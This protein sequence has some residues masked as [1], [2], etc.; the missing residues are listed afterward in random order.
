MTIRPG[1]PWGVEVAR[2]DDLVEVPDDAGLAGRPGVPTAVRGGDLFRALGAPQ[3]RDP[4]QRVEIDG[5]RVVIDDV[6]VDGVAHVVMRRGRRRGW[7]RGPIVAVMNVEHL[8]VWNVAPRA[9][10]NDGRLD[11]VEV[12]SEMS[13]RDRWT[14]RRRLPGGTHVPHPH[15]STSRSTA[16]SWRFERPIDVDVDGRRIGPAQRVEVEVVP[17]RYVVLF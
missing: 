5:I 2:P 15:V 13:L 17:D 6:E 9:H 12:R 7:W 14:A 16:Q 4:M 10:P 8:G 1:E 3:P 11:I